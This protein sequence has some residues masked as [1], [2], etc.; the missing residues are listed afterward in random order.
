MSYWIIAELNSSGQLFVVDLLVCSMTS[1]APCT[2]SDNTIVV[3]LIDLLLSSTVV[4]N[5]L[6]FYSLN[7]KG[8]DTCSDNIFLVSLIGLLLSSAA[9]AAAVD[10]RLLLVYLFVLLTKDWVRVGTII[11]L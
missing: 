3:C 5:C 7:D 2:Y 6:L 11:F 9:A 8:L 1:K 4:V 10:N